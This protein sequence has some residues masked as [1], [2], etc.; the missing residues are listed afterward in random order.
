M[1]KKSTAK[2]SSQPALHGV[3]RRKASVARV[4]LRPGKGSII[5]NGKEYSEYFSTDVTRAAVEVPFRVSSCADSV[6]AQINVV[7][8]GI[9]G[10]AFATQLGIARALLLG[11]E[12]LRVLLRKHSLLTVDARLK[13]RKKYGQK[14][15]RRKF[16][17]VKR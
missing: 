5:V 14:A 17:F 16:Q 15:A 13:E 1:A 12:T 6:D 11:D 9:T 7:G 4:W 8:G 2:A 3:G 10:Q